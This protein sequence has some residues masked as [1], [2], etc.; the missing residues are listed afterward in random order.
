MAISIRAFPLLFLASTAFAEADWSERMK[1]KNDFRFRTELLDQDSDSTPPNFRQR[2]RAR[3]GGVFQVN[4][5][6]ESGL[7][8]ASGSDDPTS[9]NQTLG[10]GSSTKSFSLDEAFAKWRPSEP[11]T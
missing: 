2:L 5:Q 7:T 1:L 10:D 8:L 9:T 4:D 11:W 6:V 3:L